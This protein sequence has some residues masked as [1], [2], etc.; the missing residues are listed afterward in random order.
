[1]KAVRSTSA[2]S[3]TGWAMGE[4]N[5]FSID[6]TRW[7]IVIITQRAPQLSDEE[8]LASLAESERA[9]EAHA[10]RYALVL[11][12]RLALPPSEAQLAMIAEQGVRSAERVRS[13]CVCS[14]LVVT[15]DRMHAMITACGWQTGKPPHT[16]VFDGLAA[17]IQ[18]TRRRLERAQ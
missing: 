15:S 9:L 1:M 4:K 18:W 17:A 13:R 5:K 2:L 10:G 12:N 8:R 14:A 16:E 11:D 3:Y 6:V 7:P